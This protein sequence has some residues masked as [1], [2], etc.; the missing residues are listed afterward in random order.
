MRRFVTSEAAWVALIAVLAGWWGTR[1]VTRFRDLGGTQS[2][3]QPYFEPAV[4][5]ACGH[6]FASAVQPSPALDDFLQQRTDTFDCAR[7]R[8][9]APLNPADRVYQYAWFYLMWMVALFWMIAG[10]SWSGLAPLFGALFATTIVLAYV[11]FR[12]AVPAWMASAAVA[13]LTVSQLHVTNLPHLRDYA[14]APFMLALFLMLVWIVKH[15]PAS[16]RLLAWCSAY[17]LVL[18]IGYGFRTDFLASIPPLFAVVLFFLPGYRP[19][20][21]AAKLGA[22]ATAMAVFV[23]VG[24]PAISYVARHGGCQWH[25]VLL[26]L[27]RSH[28]EN[29]RVTPSYYQWLTE[30]SDEYQVAAVNSALRRTG[31]PPAT[32][33]TSAYDAA[34]G[35]YLVS[36]VSRF[37]AD[38]YTRALASISLV[39]DLPFYLWTDRDPFINRS[40]LGEALTH[41]AGSSRLAVV[42]AVLAIGAVQLRW[43][44]FAVFAI[45][46]FGSYPSM[47]FAPRHFFHLEFLGWWAMAFVFWQALRLIG[48]R[49][50][51]DGPVRLPQLA[52]RGLVF[53][54][55]VAAVILLPLPVVR[56][57]HDRSVAAV[58]DALLAAPRVPVVVTSSAGGVD[59]RLESGEMLDLAPD[60]TQTALLD[61]RIDLDRCPGG[62]PLGL[63]YDHAD[64]FMDF[65]AALQPQPQG[66][67]I[68]TWLVPI[69]AGF[70]GLSLG[71]APADCLQSVQRLQSV[72]GMPVLPT[73]TLPANWRDLP[74][75]Q[76]IGAEALFLWDLGI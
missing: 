20:E 58:T 22:V 54:T 75:H 2:F 36:I 70:R 8:A 39:M 17:G 69:F 28:S 50:A 6:G 74:K 60:A 5:A 57:Y 76:R 38:V 33:C 19:R 55:V 42:L 21:L 11:I 52:R 41:V 34:S 43:A 66:A 32:Y 13:A 35:D 63:R 4:M 64:P 29:L 49:G 7:L 46:Y 3:Y 18:G 73:L 61:V 65:S 24:W 51:V 45:A 30:Y 10:V 14:K 1:A 9:E 12:L 62:V 59:L 56:G 23:V 15:P 72:K 44:L 67:V 47:Q 68:Q 37:P 71:N 16:R 31:Q 25:V 27:D 48:S 26:G 53:G 40:R